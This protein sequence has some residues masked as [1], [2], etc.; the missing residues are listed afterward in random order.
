M[1]PLLFKYLML[2]QG[3]PLLVTAGPGKTVSHERSQN[4]A[5]CLWEGLLKKS[6]EGVVC[7]MEWK[8]PDLDLHGASHSY[9]HIVYHCIHY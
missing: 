6:M 8:V 5:D 7:F 2:W 3:K 9:K 4:T 1:T